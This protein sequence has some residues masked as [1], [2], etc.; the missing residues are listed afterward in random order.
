[1]PSYALSTTKRK[2]HSILDSIAN[3]STTSLDANN[4]QHNVSTTTLAPSLEPYAK[5]L[6]VSRPSSTPVPPNSLL[7]ARSTSNRTATPRTSSASTMTE[8]KKP[9]NFA[10]WDR[11]QFLSRLETFRHVEKWMSK[12]DEIN[13]VQWAKRGWT[14]VGKETVSCVGG[15][16]NEV[17]ISLEPSREEEKPIEGLEPSEEAVDDYND[18]REEAQKELVKRYTEMIVTEHDE[19]CLWRRKGCDD[20][21]HRLPLVQQATTLLSLRTRYESLT[22]IS[23][24]LPSNISTPSTLN[25]SKLIPHLFHILHPTQASSSKPSATDH[26]SSPTNSPPPESSSNE[27]FTPP[28]I[29]PRALTLALLGWQAN[30]TAPIPGIANCETC[31][32]RLGLWLYKSP[33]S[34]PPSSPPG[35]PTSTT[36][37]S[38]ITRLDPLGEHRDYCPWINAHSQSRNPVPTDTDIPGWMI[39]QNMI[40]KLRPPGGLRAANATAVVGAG[41][42]GADGAVKEVEETRTKEE[43]DK[44]RWARLKRLKQV[45]RVRRKPKEGAEGKKV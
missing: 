37:T 2:F 26:P 21:I 35:C 14:C 7:H 19:G 12:A 9:P 34:S 27:T 38:I 13:E 32:R 23:T 24:S 25:I 41:G 28:T 11:N 4:N 10:P 29:N 40:L 8:E 36:S 45:F 31:F 17:V 15:C 33:P 5:K 30:T 20:S 16:G 44:E 42:T 3:G 1:M 39:L 6:K 18:W 22:T 43:R